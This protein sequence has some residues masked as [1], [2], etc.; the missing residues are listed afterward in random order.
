MPGTG[1]IKNINP[2]INLWNAYFL[3]II[4]KYKA[5]NPGFQNRKLKNPKKDENQA[6]FKN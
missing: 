1:S 4:Y 2:Y 3:I 5:K 6:K